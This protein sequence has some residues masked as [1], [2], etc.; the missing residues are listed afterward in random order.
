MTFSLSFIFFSTCTD[1]KRDVLFTCVNRN[2]ASIVYRPILLFSIWWMGFFSFSDRP[3]FFHIFRS[4]DLFSHFQFGLFS[5]FQATKCEKKSWN[6]KNGI[7]AMKWQLI[8]V[9]MDDFILFQMKFCCHHKK[10]FFFTLLYAICKL[11]EFFL[12]FTLT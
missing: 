9:F 4:A 8:H 7:F 11:Y 5:H 1:W 2:G 6:A 12:M 3:T 10:L